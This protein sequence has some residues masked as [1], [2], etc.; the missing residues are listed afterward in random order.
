MAGLPRARRWLKSQSDNIPSAQ[1]G[2][3]VPKKVDDPDLARAKS[4]RTGRGVVARYIGT[5]LKTSWE[6][7]NLDRYRPV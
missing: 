3:L 2:T 7:D 1:E 4:P 6:D 5:R